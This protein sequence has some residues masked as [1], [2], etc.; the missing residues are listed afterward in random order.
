[1]LIYRFYSFVACLAKCKFPYITHLSSP[2]RLSSHLHLI[3]ISHLHFSSHLFL[4]TNF[5]STF[6]SSMISQFITFLFV[7]RN[8][9][10]VYT[11][12]CK[13]GLFKGQD[14]K[15]LRYLILGNGGSFL[16]DLSLLVSTIL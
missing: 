1:M 12:N 6:S 15:H 10:T 4:S 11:R 3:S 13:L 7:S 9:Y 5:S 8:V 14:S 16:L 2:L